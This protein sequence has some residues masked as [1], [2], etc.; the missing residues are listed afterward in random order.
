MQL[1]SR[2]GLVKVYGRSDQGRRRRNN[3]DSWF[4][5]EAL[6]VAVVADGMGG[7]A[8]GEVASV[9]TVN[10]IEEIVAAAPGG[11]SPLEL[12]RAAVRLA[13]HRVISEAQYR[14]SCAGM[15]STVVAARWED[16]NLTIASVGDSRAYLFRDGALS[17]LTYDQ[18]LGNELR[19]SMGWSEEQVSRF[20]QRHVLTAAIGANTEVPIRDCSLRLVHRDWIVLCSDGLYGPLGD[21]SIAQL[22]AAA[23]HPEEAVNTLIDAANQAG[24]PDNITVVLLEYRE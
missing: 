23:G 12:L 24:G 4:V 2:M 18:N 9:L 13:N 11:V 5:D 15:G 3:E 14:P 1:L 17:Q 10:T 7:Q 19:D 8:C 6:Q 21:R 16:G 22:L 20:P